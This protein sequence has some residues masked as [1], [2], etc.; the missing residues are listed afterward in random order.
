MLP[1]ARLYDHY[2]IL[3]SSTI[4][5]NKLFRDPYL[6]LLLHCVSLYP[7]FFFLKKF[8]LL[9][10]RYPLKAVAELQHLRWRGEVKAAWGIALLPGAPGQWAS[11][12]QPQLDLGWLWVVQLEGMGLSTLCNSC[13]CLQE[14]CA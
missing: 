3:F 10:N 6:P 1:L 9:D 8:F 7:F 11:R 4:I 5:G 13:C 12:A 14:K 2:L